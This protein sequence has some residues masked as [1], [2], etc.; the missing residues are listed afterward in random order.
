LVKDESVRRCRSKTL[1]AAFVGPYQIVR[2]EGSNLV[3]RTKRSGE[4]KIHANLVKPF[5][6]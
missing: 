1:E 3:L 6:A 5:F 2:I 4:I